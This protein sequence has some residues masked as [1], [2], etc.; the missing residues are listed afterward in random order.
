M[1]ENSKIAKK[2]LIGNIDQLSTNEDKKRHRAYC[3][4]SFQKEKPKICE[5]VQYMCFSPEIC[6]TT[7]KEHWQGF[8]FFKAKDGYSIKK[9]Q[10]ILNG[11]YTIIPCNGSIEQN[12]NYCGANDY[13]KDGKKKFK[14][15]LFEEY[16]T[17]PS[18][19]KRT[20]LDDLKEEIKKGKTVEQI[21]ME[22]PKTYH[23]YGRTL[24]KIEDICVRKLFRTE[25]PKVIWYYGL[26]GVGKSHIAYENF[27]E[28][29]CYDY[30]ASD[31]GF[32]EDYRG[33][34]KVIINEFRGEIP[35]RTLLKIC[36]KFPFKCKRKGK[37]PFP[38]LCNEVI[39]TSCKTPEE[40]YSHS[41]DDEDNIDQFLRRCKVVK[42][43]KKIDDTNIKKQLDN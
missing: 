14:N 11:G 22:E 25:M 30:D 23:M 20:D 8:L 31:N 17:K 5:Q 19:G 24:Q 4:T 18:Q 7:K 43:T 1:T 9:A 10:K 35:F 37:G 42:L 27:D 21:I 28:D 29:T 13:E 15:P 26:T 38:L 36:D 2:C 32:W 34:K 39:I 40:I 6:P 41:L 12:I 33:Q 3:F 16:G